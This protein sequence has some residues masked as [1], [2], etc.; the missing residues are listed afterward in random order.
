MLS[1]TTLTGSV[2]ASENVIR[3]AGATGFSAGKVVHIDD[4]AMVVTRVDGLFIS[5]FRGRCSTAALPHASGAVAIV[6]D[7][8]D[9]VGIP[10]SIVGAAAPGVTAT[11]W[12]NGR[13]H[14]TQLAFENLPV[15]SA[16]GAANL[17]LG[18]LLYTLP[19]G[20]IL[21]KAARQSVGVLGSGALCDADTPDAGIGTTV[22][23]GA[24][25]LLSGVAG[26]ENILTGQTLA[27]CT[28]TVAT[29]ALAATLAIE[30]AGAKTVYFNLADGWAGAA[31]FTASGSVVLEW[32]RLF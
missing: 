26:A 24:Q 3:V 17:A 22:G 9:F 2:S 23:S 32:V 16:V 20:V 15:G 1:A 27:N 7:P 4:E 28:G 31:D 25:A 19:P 8:L 11:E 13:S 6:G 29:A 21:L 12:V 5:V 10:G 18:V 30:V 14:I